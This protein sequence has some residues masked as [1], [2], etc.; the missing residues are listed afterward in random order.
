MKIDFD[1]VAFMR[2][3][4]FKSKS[5]LCMAAEAIFMTIMCIVFVGYVFVLHFARRNEQRESSRWCIIWTIWKLFYV[6]CNVCNNKMQHHA[7]LQEQKS[8]IQCAVHKVF[9]WFLIEKDFSSEQY[10]IRD[11]TIWV[12]WLHIFI[13]IYVYM[14]HNTWKHQWTQPRSFNRTD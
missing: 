11:T 10:R 1:C 12:V 2:L 5:N 6:F 4:E 8:I 13:F 9:E 14:H 3:H 7:Q